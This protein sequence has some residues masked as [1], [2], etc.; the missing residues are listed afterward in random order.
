[1][2]VEVNSP[3][4]FTSA[5]FSILTKRSGVVTGQDGRDD[6]FTVEAEVP[7]NNMFGFSGE[8]RGKT[9]GKGLWKSIQI[10]TRYTF[11]FNFPIFCPLFQFV[12]LTKSLPNRLT[13]HSIHNINEILL[14][15]NNLFLDLEYLLSLSSLRN[16][17][18]RSAFKCLT[19][20]L[21]PSVGLSCCSNINS[22][23]FKRST[24]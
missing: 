10:C 17:V 19:W 15:L 8:L 23:L 5:V 11:S 2:S 18:F 1:M 22:I 4:E 24:F 21:S 16:Y 14:K 3:I 7:L 9:Q 6:W 12:R 20:D 13:W